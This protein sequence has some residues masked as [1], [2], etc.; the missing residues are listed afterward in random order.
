[1]LS[2]A[3]YVCN[4]ELYLTNVFGIGR[5]VA[6]PNGMICVLEAEPSVNHVADETAWPPQ[7]RSRPIYARRFNITWAHCRS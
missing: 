4:T 7:H 2:I 1:M 6:A 3:P 5:P